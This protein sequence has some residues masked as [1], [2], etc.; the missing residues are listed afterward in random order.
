MGK[1]IAGLVIA[2]LLTGCAISPQQFAAQRETL[3]PD[4][5]CKGRASALKNG[6][7][8]F[9]SDID[10]ELLRRGL[11]PSQCPAIIEEASRQAAAAAAIILGGLAVVAIAKSSGGGGGGYPYQPVLQDYDWEWD[12]FFDQNFQLVWAC[13][14]RQTGQFAV[15]DRCAYKWKSDNTWPSKRADTR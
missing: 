12:Q 3:R 14:G 6:D 13:R 2:A 5:L 1:E 15:L 11:G 7:Y 9:R 4:E 10:D 8:Q